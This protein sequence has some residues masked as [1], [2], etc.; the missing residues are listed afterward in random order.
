VTESQPGKDT[1]GHVM[2]PSE[3]RQIPI[4]GVPEVST[5]K[6][7]GAASGGRVSVHEEWHGADDP[8]VPRHFHHQLDEI[9][10]VLEGDMRFLVGDDEVV[11]PPGTVIYVPR[12]T[13]HAWRPTGTTPVRQFVVFIPGGFEGYLDEMRMLPPPDEAPEAW[14][15]LNRRWDVTIVGPP[16]SGE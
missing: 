10:Y 13:V 9:F 6:V 8:G 1:S 4:P 12:G 16:L 15:D 14:S 7:E 11:A 3:G 2:P 5:V